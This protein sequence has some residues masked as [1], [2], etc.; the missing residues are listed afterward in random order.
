MKERDSKHFLRIFSTYCEKCGDVKLPKDSVPFSWL[1]KPPV[2]RSE[3]TCHICEARLNEKSKA[4]V[5]EAKELILL[6]V[7]VIIDN[8]NESDEIT[9]EI[10]IMLQKL[11]R[12][13]LKT[14]IMLK[15]DLVQWHFN[16]FAAFNTLNAFVDDLI[17]YFED[18]PYWHQFEHHFGTNCTSCEDKM[19]TIQRSP[20]E[21]CE[22][23]R[24]LRENIT[25][26]KTTPMEMGILLQ[27]ADFQKDLVLSVV[28]ATLNLED[29]AV[30][31]EKTKH[32]LQIA[33][34]FGTILAQSDFTEFGKNLLVKQFHD[35]CEKLIIYFEC[36]NKK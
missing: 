4:F 22:F 30:I 16:K 5:R 26:I 8:K 17:T 12:A 28:K 25:K 31:A 9:R 33:E 14:K 34:E 32:A 1:S 10:E 20:C 15:E 23:H 21:I 19:L 18:H 35:Y 24:M 13:F 7:R 29:E 3:P 36:D 11:S 27:M 6:G 2:I